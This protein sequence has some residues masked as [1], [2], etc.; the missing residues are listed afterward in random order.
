METADVASLTPRPL[1]PLPEP[2]AGH[3]L[4]SPRRLRQWTF[5]FLLLGVLARCVRYFLRFPLW[6]DECFLCA[7]FIDRDYRGM[8]DPLHYHQVA[9]ILFLWLE[10]TVVKLFG[11]TEMTLRLIPFLAGIASLALFYRLACVCLT[12]VPRLL[13]V[14]LFS[15]TYGTIRYSAEAKPYGIDLFVSLVLVNF[16]INWLRAPARKRGLTP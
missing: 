1:F 10:L 4:F 13:A 14:A 11:Y 12:G 2:A 3:D 7:N 8:L 5:G 9:P 15:V 6:E 16:F